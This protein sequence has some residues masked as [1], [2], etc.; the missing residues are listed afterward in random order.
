MKK[1]RVVTLIDL[2]I[3]IGVIILKIWAGLVFTSYTLICSGYYSLIDVFE[4][5]LVFVSGLVRGRR[6]S[7]KQPFGFGSKEII[8]QLFIG[9]VIVCVGLFVFAKTYFLRYNTVDLQIILV[10]ILVGIAKLIYANIE[11]EESKKIQSIVLKDFAKDS[12]FDGLIT[13]SLLLFIVLAHFMPVF[14][15]LGVIIGSILILVKGSK[16]IFDSYLLLKGENTLN[17]QDKKIVEEVISKFSK[18]SYADL[19]I[20]K[21]N[22]V[23]KLTIIV[24]VDDDMTLTDFYFLEMS[25]KD[26]IKEKF[27]NFVSVELDTYVK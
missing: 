6:S 11:F 24:N 12:Y 16:I 9:F 5:S 17:K 10:V 2:L 15:M 22:N 23:W 14:D 19:D 7:K 20:I 1:E 13:L 3:S 8:C 26:K 21:I 18:V 4:D 25:I 27:G